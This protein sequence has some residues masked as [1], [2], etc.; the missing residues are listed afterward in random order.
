M[1]YQVYKNILSDKPVSFLIGHLSY[2][3]N[4]VCSNVNEAIIDDFRVMIKATLDTLS[5]RKI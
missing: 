2:L 5:E 1:I 3:E 4:E